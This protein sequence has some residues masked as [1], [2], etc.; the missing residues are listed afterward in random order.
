[1]AGRYTRAR[2]AADTLVTN[3]TPA[4]KDLPPVAMFLPVPTYVMVR[5]HKWDEVLKQQEPDKAMALDHAMW[6]WARGMAHAANRNV[7]GAEA[8]LKNLQAAQENAPAEAMVDKN[9]LATVLELAGHVLEAHVAQARK[10]YDGAQKHYQMAAQIHDNF[11][12]IEPPE[13]PFPGYESLGAMWL[14]AG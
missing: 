12:Y 4:L 8:E 10:D 14:S 9:P 7:S 3:V 13:W 2:S 5:F 1:M 11:N 6:Y